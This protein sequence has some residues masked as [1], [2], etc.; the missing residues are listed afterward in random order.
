[1][2]VLWHLYN[3]CKLLF[4]QLHSDRLL[5]LHPNPQAVSQ[6]SSLWR[7][8]PPVSVSV[9]VLEHRTGTANGT[10]SLQPPGGR[11]SVPECGGQQ[12]QDQL[13]LAHTSGASSPAVVAIEGAELALPGLVGVW[14]Q[15]GTDI[16]STLALEHHC[17]FRQQS[18]QRVSEWPLVATRAGHQQMSA[19]VGSQTQMRR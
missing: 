1:M 12:G 14:I 11:A 18:R 17:G 5:R 3:V 9:S 7:P 19:A 16:K 15:L 4:L 6:A 8:H 10:A 13:S 2:K